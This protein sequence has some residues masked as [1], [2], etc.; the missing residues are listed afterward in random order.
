MKA[1]FI[2]WFIYCLLYSMRS[3]LICAIYD[4]LTDGLQEKTNRVDFKL[5]EFVM[6]FLLDMIYVEETTTQIK[7]IG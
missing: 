4:R 5:Q 3:A 1:A 2:L 7:E 6:K